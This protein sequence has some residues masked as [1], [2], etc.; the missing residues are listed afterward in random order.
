MFASVFGELRL[1]LHVEE[2]GLMNMNPK[3]TD[4]KIWETN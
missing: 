2:P 3:L 1:V 4:G